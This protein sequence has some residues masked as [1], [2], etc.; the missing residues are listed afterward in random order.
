MSILEIDKLK[1]GQQKGIPRALIFTIALI[2][3]I[4]GYTLAAN[5]SLNSGQNVEFG[6]GVTQA[7]ACDNEITVTPQ[8]E[9]INS[10]GDDNF[11]FSSFRFLESIALQIIAMEKISL[12]R[13][14]TARE[15]YWIF[16]LIMNL[17]TRHSESGMLVAVSF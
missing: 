15:T 10:S 8:A 16:S 1:K 4:I 2:L 5:I 14:L 6:Q 3:S 9:F 11:K 12:L 7:S 17:I 13:L